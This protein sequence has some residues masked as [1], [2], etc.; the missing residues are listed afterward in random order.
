MLV[1]EEK[2]L[3]ETPLTVKSAHLTFNLYHLQRRRDG[4]TE[5][6]SETDAHEALRAGQ[7]VV[8]FN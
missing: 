5:K 2:T 4:F 1:D 6:P 7:S 8:L 3:T